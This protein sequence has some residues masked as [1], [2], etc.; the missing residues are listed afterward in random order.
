VFA[1]AQEHLARLIEIRADEI[2]TAHR[3]PP[4]LALPLGTMASA[5]ANMAAL[6]ALAAT[7]G[8]AV[9]CL[10]RLFTP[11]PPLTRTYTAPSA[12]GAP[13]PSQCRPHQPQ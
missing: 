11:P 12:A 8:D 3:N 5:T 6:S 9:Q 2:A 4:N 1:A 13:V 10:D 7:G